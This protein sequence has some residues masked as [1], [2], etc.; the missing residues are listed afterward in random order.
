[1]PTALVSFSNLV[2]YMDEEIITLMSVFIL[3]SKNISHTVHSSSLRK[4]TP[5]KFFFLLY[6]IYRIFH[7]SLHSFFRGQ[8]NKANFKI[9]LILTHSKV[10][11]ISL[12]K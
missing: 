6:S 12:A 8:S 3:Y 9:G 1:M 4:K 2:V 5:C 7:M 11:D 10:P